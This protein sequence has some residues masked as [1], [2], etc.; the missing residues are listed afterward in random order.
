MSA[1][2]K[3][4][5]EFSA[6]LGSSPSGSMKPDMAKD[7]ECGRASTHR[8]ALCTEIFRDDG[9]QLK[10]SVRD[11]RTI[12]RGRP[13]SREWKAFIHISQTHT[14]STCAD[15]E[16]ARSTSFVSRCACA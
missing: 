11:V 12:R 15:D 4:L 5:S 2:S 10:T 1:S 14:I 7:W 13:R 6:L 3:S 16:S 8:L 9:R